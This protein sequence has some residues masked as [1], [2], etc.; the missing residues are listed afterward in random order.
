MSWESNSG[1]IP[2]TS[3]KLSE[4]IV[5]DLL[6]LNKNI[7]L[8]YVKL[9]SAQRNPLIGFYSAHKNPNVYFS[10]PREVPSV[11]SR[12]RVLKSI[13]SPEFFIQFFGL[14]FRTFPVFI[15]TEFLLQ[16]Y[17]VAVTS[18]RLVHSFSIFVE[19]LF[20][21]VMNFF[22]TRVLPHS[23]MNFSLKWTDLASKVKWVTCTLI[24]GYLR[25]TN[26]SSQSFSGFTIEITLHL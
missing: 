7:P 18:N 13:F 17:D 8:H 20:I 10:L 24:E 23:Q 9:N 21:C 6:S 25:A 14:Y 2:A 15:S 11:G 3:D 4:Q 5:Y 12:T 22:V 19:S 16:Q 1:I 26:G